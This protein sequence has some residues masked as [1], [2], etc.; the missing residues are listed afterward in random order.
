VPELVAVL[1]SHGWHVE[2]LPTAG[3]GSAPGQVLARI[4]HGDLGAVFAYGGD[5]T[6][7]EA[8]QGLVGSDVALAPL[9]GGTTNVVCHSL[10]LPADPVTAADA[11]ACGVSRE[12]SVGRLGDQVFLMQVS[13]GID[14]AV[15]ASVTG[16]SK[17]RW[18]RGAVLVEG[19]VLAARHRFEPIEV[20][21]GHEV[22]AG[23]FVAIANLP[24]YAGPF[25]LAEVA[26]HEPELELVVHRATGRRAAFGFTADLIRG[27]HGER[28]DVLRRR[29]Q[30]V[31]LLGPREIPLQIDGDVCDATLPVTAR[32]ASE[33]LRVLVSR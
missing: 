17:A 20:Q 29:V 2:L 33:R 21:H 15:M 23:S 8:A 24:H 19:L 18:G 28:P 30:A 1:R 5:G 27:R 9:P 31:T 16:E 12:I 3:P 11:L 26:A 4:E 13:A 25:E 22:I 10:G 6:L 14:A 32:V 7:R